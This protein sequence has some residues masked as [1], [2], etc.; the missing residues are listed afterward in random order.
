MTQTNELNLPEK[1]KTT[2]NLTLLRYVGFDVQAYESML[3]L[4]QNDP[5]M[6][7][8]ITTNQLIEQLASVFG[9]ALLLNDELMPSPRSIKGFARSDCDLYDY[10]MNHKPMA[11]AK[12]YLE[13]V[14][15]PFIVQVKCPDHYSIPYYQMLLNMTLNIILSGGEDYDFNEIMIIKP[16]YNSQFTSFSFD[17]DRKFVNRD[18]MRIMNKML[19]KKNNNIPFP[20]TSQ[21]L[22]VRVQTHYQPQLEHIRWLLA[23]QQLYTAFMNLYTNPMSQLPQKKIAQKEIEKKSQ[24]KPA[25]DGY[26]A[27]D[28]EICTVLLIDK[29]IEIQE[30]EIKKEHLETTKPCWRN[31]KVD[32]YYAFHL[33][34]WDIKGLNVIHPFIEKACKKAGYYSEYR[35]FKCHNPFLTNGKAKKNN[36]QPVLRKLIRTEY[37]NAKPDY[38]DDHL[39]M[40][41]NRFISR[42]E[43]M[44]D[45]QEFEKYKP[46]A[47]IYGK[48]HQ[49][50]FRALNEYFRIRAERGHN[51]IDK[52]HLK[53]M[54]G[55]I[56][57]I[58]VMIQCYHQSLGEINDDDE[59]NLE[60]KLFVRYC[61]ECSDITDSFLDRLGSIISSYML[62]ITTSATMTSREDRFGL[63]YLFYPFYFNGA[64][65]DNEYKRKYFNFMRLAYKQP[66]VRYITTIEHTER[67]EVSGT[68]MLITR[69]THPETMARRYVIV[70]GRIYITFKNLDSVTYRADVPLQLQ[71][72]IV[73]ELYDS[74]FIAAGSLNSAEIILFDPLGDLIRSIDIPIH[75]RIESIIPLLEINTVT[76]TRQIVTNTFEQVTKATIK[77]IP[78]IDIGFTTHAS[79]RKINVNVIK[80]R[81]HEYK[82]LNVKTILIV[83]TI[84]YENVDDPQLRKTIRLICYDMKSLPKT[85]ETSKSV[86]IRISKAMYIT[87]KH[88][89]PRYSNYI[90]FE[91]NY[92]NLR[93]IMKELFSIVRLSKPYYEN[94]E[95][96][97]IKY[98]PLKL[99][100]YEYLTR[101]TGLAVF[102]QF[103]APQLKLPITTERIKVKSTHKFAFDY[104]TE[105]TEHRMQSMADYVIV[106][107]K[108]TIY[109]GIDK[110]KNKT[111][112]EM[113]LQDYLENDAYKF[114]RECGTVL[115]GVYDRMRDAFT[116]RR[117]ADIIEIINEDGLQEIHMI[118]EDGNDMVMVEEDDFED[119][120]QDQEWEQANIEGEMW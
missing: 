49:F 53:I 7:K 106:D 89:L 69:W 27:D 9:D 78:C 88:K 111:V 13:G 37:P 55:I 34:R 68:E 31:T 48:C 11:S 101:V 97:Y 58:A 92:Y 50:Y 43:N 90:S 40:L 113:V 26:D 75:Y 2:F 32:Y 46:L 108:D 61:G 117:I 17:Y 15:E 18:R 80:H 82:D 120:D 110:Y 29:T 51:K 24:F 20:L 66:L 4:Q 86:E 79:D 91:T 64:T 114:D 56:G 3:N 30:T 44:K 33:K 63:K 105:A 22:S 76:K 39:T 83:L 103:F 21:K 65:E 45:F 10:L 87:P 70:R 60:P 19:S 107:R 104:E 16:V 71:K 118:D 72:R 42:M 38:V 6:Y 77:I 85:E 28:T 12:F 116:R 102:G 96:D 112:R 1:L 67:K 62:V 98:Y 119:E 5:Q 23:N 94:G 99:F 8:L 52:K 81:S 93:K 36:L 73:G 25:Y 95:G 84:V 115:R 41:V 59:E 109:Q 54:Y 74:L 100:V 14:K 35:K 47:S 57:F